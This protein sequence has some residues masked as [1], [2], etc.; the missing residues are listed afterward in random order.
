VSKEPTTQNSPSTPLKKVKTTGRYKIGLYGGISCGIFALILQL[1]ISIP[2]DIEQYTQKQ[3]IT[4]ETE[5]EKTQLQAE[6]AIKTETAKQQKLQ[7]ESYAQ[8]E[9]NPVKSFAIWGYI[10]NPKKKPP[11]DLRAFPNNRQKVYIFDASNR[12]IGFVQ[13]RKL[14]WKHT[15]NNQK[16]CQGINNND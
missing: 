10:D 7:A 4:Q 3:Q 8:N 16:I 5:R 13:N 2:S 6:T 1:F 12:C 11:I 14:Y 9:I 15:K